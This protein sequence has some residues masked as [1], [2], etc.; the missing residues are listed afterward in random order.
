M[1]NSRLNRNSKLKA[2]ALRYYPPECAVCGE[3]DLKLELDHIVPITEGGEDELYNVQL[4]CA[5]C[6]RQKTN[7]QRRQRMNRVTSDGQ[8]VK[9][10]FPIPKPKPKPAGSRSR[11]SGRQNGW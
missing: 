5:E 10:D 4:L 6:H 1:T 7:F 9:G 11:Y 3:T 8:V 2:Q